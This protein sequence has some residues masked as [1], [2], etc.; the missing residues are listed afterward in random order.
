MIGTCT[1]EYDAKVPIAVNV[2]LA[3]ARI[4]GVVVQPG[5]SFSFSSTIL[6]R[7]SANGYVVAPIYISGTVGTGT[8]GGV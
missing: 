8:G 3:A 7:T 1:T 2:E 6:P 4:N 5:K